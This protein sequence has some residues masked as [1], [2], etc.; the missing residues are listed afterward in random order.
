MKS[1]SG[2]L[3][4]DSFIKRYVFE[5]KKGQGGF[6]KAFVVYDKEKQK[7]CIAK[8]ILIKDKEKNNKI[9]IKEK[10]DLFDREIRIMARITEAHNPN[11]IQLIDHGE[12]NI[13]R[14]EHKGEIKKYMILEYAKNRELFD[15]ICYAK[16]GFGETFGKKIFSKII[17]G[18]ETIHDLGYCHKDLSLSNIFLDELYE[19]KI[20]DF[21][22]AMENRNDL[23]EFISTPGFQAPEI[24][25]KLPHD[26]QKADIF[27]LGQILFL[28]V[29][30][31]KGFDKPNRQ[32]EF[33]KLII[34]KEEKNSLKE[35]EECLKNYW[36]K[37]GA[38]I[39]NEIISEDFKDLYMKMVCPNP[40]NRLTI[41][42]I[43]E[44][45]WVISASKIDEEL[46]KEF[47]K[48]KNEIKDKVTEEIEEMKD[49]NLTLI[50]NKHETRGIKGEQVFNSDKEPKKFPEYY[51]ERFCIIFKGYSKNNA[52]K[53]MNNLY[54]IITK[55]GIIEYCADKFKMV[56]EFEDEQEEVID[57]KIK[58]Y[59][60]QNG[61]ILKFFR[62]CGDKKGFFDKFKEIAGLV[63]N[64]N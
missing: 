61:L 12:S 35:K 11:I 43:L 51:N 37:I 36:K 49:D 7:E 21:G 9:K 33:Y 46:R 60:I 63:S 8:F 13:E 50:G 62:K 5:E 24:I 6:G 59:Q 38:S 27:S 39:K 64:K 56:I 32:D 34:E 54:K 30:G 44:H 29:F 48:R 4:L 14:R 47:R 15:Y 52:N 55:F 31:K 53:I 16:Q 1:K 19:P 23:E 18:M 41:R 10:Y 57:M 45:P 28:I 22:A 40:A 17:K 3:E 20:G 25:E 26:G 42:Q 2:P 58:L